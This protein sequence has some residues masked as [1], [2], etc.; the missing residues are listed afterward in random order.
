MMRERERERSCTAATCAPC[1]GRR[2][3]AVQAAAPCSR[4]QHCQAW[5]GI[6]L[7]HGEGA[8]RILLCNLPCCIA[9]R[10]GAHSVQVAVQVCREQ[11]QLSRA[12]LLPVCY[13]I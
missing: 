2:L 8:K 11:E 10:R 13:P 12:L 5:L 9:A 1:A 6:M 3:A 7:W 4:R